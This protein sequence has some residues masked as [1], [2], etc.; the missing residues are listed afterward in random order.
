MADGRV[1]HGRII[2]EDR[3]VIVFEYIE[4]RLGL[5]SKLRLDPADV[6]KIERNEVILTLMVATK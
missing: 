4:R 5:K 6:L 3:Y 2:S 1:L